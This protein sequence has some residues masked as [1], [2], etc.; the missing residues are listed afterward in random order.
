LGLAGGCLGVGELG[1]EGLGVGGLGVGGLGVGVER[2]SSRYHG[3]SR[4][5]A[6]DVTKSVGRL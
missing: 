4:A 5:M 6:L 1:V 3:L 2:V